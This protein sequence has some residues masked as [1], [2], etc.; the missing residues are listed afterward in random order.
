MTER[1]TAR[2]RGSSSSTVTGS[3]VSLP[4]TL[5]EALSP[6]SSTSTPASSKTWAV[7][8]S[9][10]VSIAKRSP[11]CFSSRRCWVRMRLSGLVARSVGAADP[12]P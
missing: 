2:V 5:L 9:Y 6:T 8:M 1:E 10:A 4:K 3:E 11:R 7:Y 12:V